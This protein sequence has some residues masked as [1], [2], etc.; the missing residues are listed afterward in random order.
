M[1]SRCDKC[2]EAV[3]SIDAGF[4][5]GLH[6]MRHDCGGTWREVDA[7][8]VTVT[9]LNTTGLD[10]LLTLTAGYYPTVEDVD[11]AIERAE[12]AAA[13][14]AT[15]EQRQNWKTDLAN[16]RRIRLNHDSHEGREP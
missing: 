4:S 3:E 15:E 16:L 5:P 7:R 14:S 6:E 2:G 9:P 12:A 1:R 13:R 8:A 10:P 11:A